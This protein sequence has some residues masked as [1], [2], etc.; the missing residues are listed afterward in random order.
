MSA[1]AIEWR[2]I[3]GYEGLYEVSECGKVRSVGRVVLRK[4]GRPYRITDRIIR[5]TIAD[6]YYIV[7]LCKDAVVTRWRVHRLVANAFVGNSDGLFVLHSDG[8]PTNNHASN[9]RVGTAADNSV[10]M[11]RHG[12]STRGT[13]H[14]GSK[15]TDE[16]VASIRSSHETHAVL[17]FK[18]GV[19]RQT[20]GDI[21]T[22]RRWGWLKIAA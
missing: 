10:D 9:L 4:N 18:Y 19:A 1:H 20:I 5:G 14:H 16:E 13:K 8:N 7:S 22:G 17:A 21:K 11:V 6:G 3:K 12:R 15:L 2:A